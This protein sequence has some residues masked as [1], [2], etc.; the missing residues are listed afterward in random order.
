MCCASC[1]RLTAFWQSGL[2][3]PKVSSW[4]VASSGISRLVQLSCVRSTFLAERSQQATEDPLLI[5][6][7][8]KRSARLIRGHEREERTGGII[9]LA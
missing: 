4:F 5:S 3:D 1:R 7:G 9:F 6:F 8:I 2:S